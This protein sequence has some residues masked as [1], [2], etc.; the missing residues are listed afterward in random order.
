MSLDTRYL[1][2]GKKTLYVAIDSSV[3]PVVR[4]VGETKEDIPKNIRYHLPDGEPKFIGPDI[5]AILHVQDIF[6][7]NFPAC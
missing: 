4:Y 7:P 3:R 5:A 6:Y 2:N 1:T